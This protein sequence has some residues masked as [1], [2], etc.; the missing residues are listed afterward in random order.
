MREREREKEGWERQRKA[1]GLNRASSEKAAALANDPCDA[2]NVSRL[3]SDY[4]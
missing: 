1:K 2:S 4:S 3:E